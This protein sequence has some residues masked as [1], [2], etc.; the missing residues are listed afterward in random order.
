MQPV[1]RPGSKP[2]TVYDIWKPPDQRPLRQLPGLLGS[3]LALLWAAAPREF[4]LVAILQIASGAMAGV[5][6]VLV[7][8]LLDAI[9]AASASQDF[10]PLLAW[11]GLLAVLT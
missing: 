5:M 7:R 11:L 1:A 8:N 3:S 2:Q 10:G 4:V 6:L 9:Q